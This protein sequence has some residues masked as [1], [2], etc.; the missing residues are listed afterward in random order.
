M[1]TDHPPHDGATPAGEPDRQQMVAVARV[2]ERTGRRVTTLEEH[3]RRLAGEMTRVAG[4][5][6]AQPATPSPG[7]GESTGEVAAPVVTSWLLAAGTDAD[8][9]PAALADLISWL[10]L[11]YLRFPDALLTGCWLWHPSVIEELWWLRGA[12]ADAYDPETGSWLRVGDWHDRQRPGVA[13]RVRDVLAKCDLSLHTSDRNDRGPAAEP[14]P[15][16]LAGHAAAIA[17]EWGRSGTRP[18]PSGEQIDEARAM[19]ATQVRG[20]R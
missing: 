14:S 12:H 15:A 8:E 1:S 4:V 13:R 11:V 9:L 18:A 17:A 10:D 7:P 19:A 20:R 2:L 6:A 3:V 5:V 16:P